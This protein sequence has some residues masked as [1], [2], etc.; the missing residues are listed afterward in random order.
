MLGIDR[1]L[2]RAHRHLEGV[3]GVDHQRVG[4]GD[5]RVPVGGVDIGADLPGRIG[6]R[7][8]ERDD[9]LLQPHLQ[10]A[11]RHR[12]GA[13]EFQFEIVEPAA[14]Q[15]R[16]AA[17]SCDQRVDRRPSL[18]A[19]VPLMP[20]CG[21]Q[22]A[23]LQ[24]R[25]RRRTR[26]AARAARGNPAAR[27]IGRRRQPCK[28]WAPVYQAARA[29]ENPLA[30]PIPADRSHSWYAS[31]CRGPPEC[32]MKAGLPASRASHHHDT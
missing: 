31:H 24:R 1:A 11:E 29:R 22:H 17:S 20:S 6:G 32:A 19:S 7:V 10:P 13:R 23:A 26:A 14:E 3:A 9:L 8:A 4:R 15:R 25:G 21:E 27:R 16:R 2:E 30:Q 28:S 18:P 5:Q 12:L